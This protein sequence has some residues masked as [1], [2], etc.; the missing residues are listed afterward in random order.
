[1]IAK[2]RLLSQRNKFLMIAMSSPSLT[3]LLIAAYFVLLFATLILRSRTIT[4]PWLFLLRSFFP[5]WRFYHRVGHLR[6][7]FIRIADAD[8]KWQA[9]QDMTP[10]TR[11]LPLPLQLLH[12]PDINLALANQNLV[13]HLTTDILDMDEAQNVRQF[14]TYQLVMRLVRH[15]LQPQAEQHAIT[16]YQFQ[17]RLVPPFEDATEETAL[18][19]S[20]AIPWASPC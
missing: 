14:V 6:L 7:L 13:E 18:L 8:Q 9:W 3:H 20:P 4:G 5:N 15:L 10:R 11:R 2:H 17:I 1:M 19:T 12:N 16:R